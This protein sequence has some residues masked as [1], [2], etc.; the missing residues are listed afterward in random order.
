[1]EDVLQGQKTGPVKED[2]AGVRGRFSANGSSP[3]ASHHPTN[4]FP[5]QKQKN[6]EAVNLG[7][8]GPGL[9]GKSPGENFTRKENGD[10]SE[11]ITSSSGEGSGGGLH[12]VACDCRCF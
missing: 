8:G 9:H 3:A 2:S 10:N 1:M 5:Q 12:V 11:E 7:H 4:H 6:N